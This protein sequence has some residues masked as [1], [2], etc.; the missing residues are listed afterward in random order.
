[1]A[2]VVIPGFRK[3]EVSGGGGG[4]VISK[5]V[6]VSTTPIDGGNRVTF[7]YTLDDGTVKTSTM[8]VM[9]GKDG[10]EPTITIGANNNWFV[11]GVDT[12]VKAKG[13]KGDTGSGFNTTRQYSSVSDMMADTNPAN[14]SEIVVVVLGDVGNFYMRLSSYIDPDG[15]TNGYLPIGSAQDIS[16]IKGEP[17]KD[18]TDGRREEFGC[19]SSEACH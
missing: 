6:I 12:G 7:S 15:E 11:D 10:K 17:G 13:E 18:G 8:D 3:I 4:E 5:N 16:A 9:D 19:S 14:D 1:M 2:R